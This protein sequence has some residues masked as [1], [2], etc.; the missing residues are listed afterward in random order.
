MKKAA[1]ESMSG[2]RQKITDVNRQLDLIES[3][4]KLRQIRAQSS[5]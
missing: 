3:L 2:V 4:V 1:D 5:G